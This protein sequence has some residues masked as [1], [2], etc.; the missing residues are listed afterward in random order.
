MMVF[1]MGRWGPLLLS[2]SL[3]DAAAFSWLLGDCFCAVQPRMAAW[4]SGISP[5][6]WILAPLPWNLQQTLGF[7]IVSS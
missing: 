1:C 3:T 4:P 7:P 5:Q 6:C 2:I